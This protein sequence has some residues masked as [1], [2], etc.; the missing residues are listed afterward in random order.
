[1]RDPLAVATRKAVLTGKRTVTVERRS[2]KG[3]ILTPSSLPCLGNLPTINITEGC[4]HGCTYC[5]TRGYANYPGK[6]RV[7]LFENTPALVRTELARKRKR[8]QRVYFSPSSDAFQPLPEVEQ[9]TY[10]TMELLLGSGIEVAFLTKGVVGKR[11]I[12]LFARTPSL[13]FAQ[14]GITT[15]NTGLWQMF[16][17]GAAPPAGRLATIDTLISAG[18]STRARLDPLIPGLTDTDENLAPLLAELQRRNMRNVAASHL[19]LRPAFAHRVLAQLSACATPAI[20]ADSWSWQALAKGVGNGQ[21]IAT[22]ERRRR[23]AHLRELGSR[24]DIDVH[25]CTCK[26]PDLASDGCQ[27]AGPLLAS[28]R[29]EELPLFD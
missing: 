11:F 21:M 28:A 23:F 1:M 20:A 5:Y 19:F 8:P 9:V 25:I 18:V 12:D 15:L 22:E 4:C 17:P 7:V 6:S 16:E 14:I 2:R 26:N 3:P 13:L 10:D 29:N 24:H 27:I